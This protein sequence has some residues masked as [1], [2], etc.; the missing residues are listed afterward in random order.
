MLKAK[1]LVLPVLLSRCILLGEVIDA[2]LY[3]CGY[4]RFALQDYGN[5]NKYT[6]HLCL[7]FGKDRR[8]SQLR[9]HLSKEQP[10][11]NPLLV[12]SVSSVVQKNDSGIIMTDNSNKPECDRTVRNSGINPLSPGIKLHILILCFHTFLTKVVG[13][14]CENINRI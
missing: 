1:R 12:S 10:A 8:A 7:W 9:W 13:R 5:W 4:L 3:T 14:S 11:E 2:I 6:N